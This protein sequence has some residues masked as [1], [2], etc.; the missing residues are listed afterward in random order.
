MIYNMKVDKIWYFFV[1]RE[2][3]TKKNDNLIKGQIICATLL[4]WYQ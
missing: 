2:K 1:N 4:H 3:H